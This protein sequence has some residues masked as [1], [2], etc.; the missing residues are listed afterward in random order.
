MHVWINDSDVAVRSDLAPT[1]TISVHGHV[2]NQT[3][4]RLVPPPVAGTHTSTPVSAWP[5]V[6]LGEIRAWLTERATVGVG[7]STEE[8]HAISQL[9][10][11][12]PAPAPTD[13]AAPG[14]VLRTHGNIEPLPDRPLGMA[15]VVVGET[16]PPAPRVT[17]PVTP[18]AEPVYP[19]SD[20]D[21]AD[22]DDIPF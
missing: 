11:P 13:A 10:I 6:T 19:N 20:G 15:V 3:V 8:L 12:P 14:F 17:A 7:V 2:S 16:V 5:T 22:D 9:L 18:A 21:A 1:A 4:L